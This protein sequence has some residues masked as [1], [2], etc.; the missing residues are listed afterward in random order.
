M[1]KKIAKTLKKAKKIAI[2]THLNPDGDALGSAFAMKRVLESIGKETELFLEKEIPQKFRFLGDDYCIGDEK[3]VSNADVALVL[4]CGDYG[5][6]GSLQDTCRAI[7]TVLC[8][9]H[10]V[11]GENFGTL[12]YKEPD[13][14]ATAQIVYKLACLITRTIPKTAC[15]AMY[16]GISTD[17]GHFKFSSVTPKTHEVTAVLIRNGIDHRAITRNLYDTV[18]HEKLIFMGKAAESIEFFA[19]GRIALL[20]CPEEFIGTYGLKYEDLEELPNLAL[21]IEGVLA[22]VLVKDKDETSKRVSL[23]GKDVIDLSIIAKDFGGGGHKNAAA[24]VAEG[25]TD[26]ILQ[27]LIETITNKLGE[28]HV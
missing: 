11:S 2:F 3:T 26:F 20:R 22:S 9:D 5:R 27:K 28:Q 4:D 23:R 15:E 13:S 21:S 1:L 6:I 19:D 8:V 24:F 12:C 7:P 14:P 16:T 17:T 18:K 25:D 10:H